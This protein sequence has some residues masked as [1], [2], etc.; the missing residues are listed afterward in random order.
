MGAGDQ[1]GGKWRVIVSGYKV[2][3][4]GDE[5]VVELGRGDGCTTL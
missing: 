3:F 2:S 4:W 5:N 1:G